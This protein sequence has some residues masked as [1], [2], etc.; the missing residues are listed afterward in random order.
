M[1]YDYLLK[2]LILGNSGVG[3]TSFMYQFVDGRFNERYISTVGVDFREK[4]L[5]FQP[6]DGGRTQRINLQL[7]D[8]AGQERFRSLTTAFFRDAMGFILMFD[9]TNEQ[10]FIDVSNWMVQLQTHAYTETPD[11]ILCGN[12][13]DLEDQRA[14]TKRNALDLAERYG[15]I[16]F[17]TSALTSVGLANSVRR[18][19]QM[20][21]NRIEESV[22]NDY[23]AFKQ[24]VESIQMAAPNRPD[25]DYQDDFDSDEERERK[26]HCHYC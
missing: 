13:L 14:V 15:L 19:V 6:L 9:L 24:R 1:E 7:W 11:I 26:S 10:S 5:T 23:P 18:L 4:R 3:K 21:M 8:T 12:K 20:V 25:F 17:E 22:E 16:Y 2:F